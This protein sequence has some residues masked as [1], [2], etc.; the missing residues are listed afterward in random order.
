MK[1]TRADLW[2]TATLLLVAVLVGGVLLTTVPRGSVVSVV[3]NDVEVARLPL[4]T[5]TTY[6][7]ANGYL[8]VIE[9]G[10]AYM[11]AAPCPDRICVHTGAISRVGETI[12]CLP[13]HVVITVEE[14]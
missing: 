14:S 13:G 8:F 4:D 11:E 5:D 12:V 1:V 7:P 2:L 9:D 3:V 6:S 10:R